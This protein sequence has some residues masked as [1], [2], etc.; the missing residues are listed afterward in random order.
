MQARVCG[1]GKDV[2]VGD[3]Q[4]AKTRTRQ[5]DCD[6]KLDAMIQQTEGQVAMWDG[7]DKARLMGCVDQSHM[8][9]FRQLSFML[10]CASKRRAT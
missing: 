9:M 1:R 2:F 10:V 3:S 7:S 4:R 8:S 5:A 6:A